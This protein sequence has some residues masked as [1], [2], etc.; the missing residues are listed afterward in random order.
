MNRLKG[1]IREKKS[2]EG[3]RP[4][5]GVKKEQ[6]KFGDFRF[7]YMKACQHDL[8]GVQ[9][10]CPVCQMANRIS[11]IFLKEEREQRAHNRIT[12][13]IKRANLRYELLSGWAHNQGLF[14]EGMNEAKIGCEVVMSGQLALS[15]VRTCEH[16]GLDFDQ[17]HKLLELRIRLLEIGHEAATFIQCRVRKWL[18][19]RRVR[20]F[21]LKRFVW[22]P[23]TRMRPQDT[24]VDSQTTTRYFQNP[25]LLRNE[26]PASPRA[27]QRRLNSEQ[28]KT[29]MRT[30]VYQDLLPKIMKDDKYGEY[31]KMI[32]D[33]RQLALFQETVETGMKY[34]RMDKIKD[35]VEE[36]N[37]EEEELEYEQE[38]ENGTGEG[39]EGGE[40]ETDEQRVKREKREAKEKIAREMTFIPVMSA[41]FPPLRH[42][43]L[44]R[45]LDTEPL[46]DP[47]PAP[48]PKSKRAPRPPKAPQIT[49]NEKFKELEKRRWDGMRCKTSKDVLEMVLHDENHPCFCSILHIASDEYEIWHSHLDPK[50]VTP[51]DREGRPLDRAN[52]EGKGAD[53]EQGYDEGNEV[54]N[55]MV[56]EASHAAVL[57]I[58]MKLLRFPPPDRG[59]NGHFRMF[60]L[61]GEFVA[62]TQASTLAYYEEVKLNRDAIKDELKSFARRRDVQKILARAAR[63]AEERRD[64]EMPLGRDMLAS[65]IQDKLLTLYAPSESEIYGADVKLAP[66]ESEETNVSDEDILRLGE[67][68]SFLL[69]L[70]KFKERF[71]QAQKKVRAKSNKKKKKKVET[72][73][74]FDFSD[75][76][77]KKIELIGGQSLEPVF[78]GSTIPLPIHDKPVGLKVFEGN[79]ERAP[80]GRGELLRLRERCM[81]GLRTNAKPKEEEE[82]EKFALVPLKSD[83]PDVEKPPLEER[84]IGEEIYKDSLAQLMSVTEVGFQ[85]RIMNDVIEKLLEEARKREHEDTPPLMYDIGVMDVTI[86]LDDRP[87]QAALLDMVGMFSSQH[88][89]PPPSLDMGLL[90]WSFFYR[91]YEDALRGMNGDNDDDEMKRLFNTTGAHPVLGDARP[92]SRPGSRSSRP[93]TSASESAAGWTEPISQDNT[94]S[95]SPLKGSGVAV[96]QREESGRNFEF[97]ILAEPMSKLYVETHFPAGIC[98]WVGLE[99]KVP[100]YVKRAED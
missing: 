57:P 25:V 51:R 93:G 64:K 68:H 14:V 32:R 66:D 60:F 10:Q 2:R 40:K 86:N 38:L 78:V 49:L 23:G 15:C 50:E 34:L 95:T 28:R 96:Y 84:V 80:G 30:K 36:E 76:N 8:K 54:E 67:T 33:L 13:T 98:T 88:M 89:Q 91:S 81:D 20:R 65:K 90:D 52:N 70:S 53:G 7:D 45:A 59:P 41:P 26:R 19:Q 31:V 6:R 37:E 99:R 56:N 75:S 21:M 100:K 79:I 48:T 77:I 55:Q 85:D 94:E 58:F 11:E 18:L 62:A 44:Q 74:N 46:K 3:K 47:E 83:D 42:I 24:W 43:A 4:G 35:P 9:A 22:E 5:K 72:F 82:R 61:N 97:R 17:L 73:D 92:N 29:D 63:S 71:R 39:E 87:M 16:W 69:K 12:S 1:A 27:I